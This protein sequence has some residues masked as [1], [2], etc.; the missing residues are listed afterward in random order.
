VQVAG[1]GVELLRAIREAVE[2]DDAAL[3]GR[4]VIVEPRKREWIDRGIRRVACDQIVNARARVVEPR[5]RPDLRAGC[6]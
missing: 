6:A 2:Q 1:E 5:V 4:A 3:R